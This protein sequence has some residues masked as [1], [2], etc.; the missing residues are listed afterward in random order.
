MAN[1][2]RCAEYEPAL[3]LAGKLA[4]WVMEDFNYYGPDGQFLEEYPGASHVHFCGG[5]GVHFHGHTGLLVGLLDYGTISG[6]QE[7][8]D[9][10][11]RDSNTG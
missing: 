2:A 5:S 6:D 7:A 4:R 1:Y 11:H 8:V 3:E 10:A 9:F